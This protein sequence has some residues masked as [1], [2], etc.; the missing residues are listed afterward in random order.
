[1]TF[2]EIAQNYIAQ[3]FTKPISGV[4]GI[5][6]LI[7]ATATVAPIIPAQQEDLFVG[8][9]QDQDYIN[10]V[11]QNN[12]SGIMKALRS[13]PGPFNLVLDMLKGED[14]AVTSMRN[15]Y[16][17]QYDLTGAGSLASGIMRG[18]NPVSGG[19]FGQPI[20]Y[21][22]AD[23]ARERIQNILNRKAPQ[24]EA[25][26]AKIQQ[27]QDFARADTISRARQANPS[28]YEGRSG[29][30]DTSAADRAGTSAGSGQ[31][32]SNKSGRGRTGF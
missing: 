4:S 20:S 6:T 15:F 28:V 21:G 23:A 12:Q 11:D 3:G 13:L 16:R 25:S 22:L 18:Y 2:D 30:F 19:L 14:P 31:G 10:Q 24:T 7:P 32:F 29:G 17:N 27:L 26:Q 5:E 8:D 9:E 1:M